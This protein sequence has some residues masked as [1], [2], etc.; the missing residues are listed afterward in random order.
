MSETSYE[1]FRAGTGNVLGK[2]KELIHE[3]KRCRKPGVTPSRSPWQAARGE[4]D[5]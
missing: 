5:S 4:C 2:I 3:S 1:S